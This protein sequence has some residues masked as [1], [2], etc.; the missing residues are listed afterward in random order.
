MKII[1]DFF[2]QNIL[3]KFISFCVAMA[4]W[5][6][7][8]TLEDPITTRNFIVNL[9]IR[10]IDEL[11]NHRLVL[12]NKNQLE[13]MSISVSASART[14]SF[15]NISQNNI[16]AYIDVSS[17]NFNIPNV[18]ADLVE[19]IVNVE[20]N[21]TEFITNVVARP[22]SVGLSLD[23]IV[24]K[25]FPISVEKISDVGVG[26]VSKSPSVN[27]ETVR[28]KGPKSLIESI[29]SVV[30]DINLEGI[31][32]NFTTRVVPTVYNGDRT[33]ISS[34]LLVYPFEIE[35]R[36]P[37]SRY[38]TIP[39]VSPIAIGTV[40][41]GY[42]LAGISYYPHHIEV[43]GRVDDINRLESILI[44]SF[45]I[46]G[47]THNTSFMFD[48]RDILKE[49]NL[50]IRLGTPHQVAVN[51]DIKPEI[52]NSLEIPISKFEIIGQTPYM[53][54]EDNIVVVG[55]LENISYNDITGIINVENLQVG[56]HDV[57]VELSILLGFT[58]TAEPITTVVIVNDP[59]QSLQPNQQGN[60]EIIEP[61]KDLEVPPEIAYDNEIHIEESG[62][63]M[64][65]TQE[66]IYEIIV[67]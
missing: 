40:A 19:T 18:T 47:Y 37:V 67:E 33:N 29:D 1:H 16:S 3:W 55:D 54:F 10:N 9:Q 7:V 42:D 51:I 24:S 4:G 57:E 30:A 61:I 59:E 31:T 53:E 8:I 12:L 15:Y 28:V 64:D 60:T 39:I 13:D 6:I 63:D 66:T 50:N 46:S 44:G 52:I 56:I 41:Q 2:T 20:V 43:V 27:I 34:E 26:F 23:D 45:D 38:A 32:D 58:D 17:L 11:D 49:Y 62:S 14:S 48:V 35:V 65:N 21:T 25:E 36:V 5:F 22:I